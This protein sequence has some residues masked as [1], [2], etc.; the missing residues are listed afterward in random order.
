MQLYAFQSDN[1]L[2][3]Q[4]N[5]IHVYIRNTEFVFSILYTYH[6]NINNMFVLYVHTVFLTLALCNTQIKPHEDTC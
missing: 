6:K 2:Y 4:Q 5:K 3:E 1:K